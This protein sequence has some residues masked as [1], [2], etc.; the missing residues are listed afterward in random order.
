MPE[1]HG[2][3]RREFFARTAGGALGLTGVSLLAACGQQTPP[4]P[5]AAPKPTEAAKPAAAGQATAAP[6]PAATAQPAATAAPTAAPAAAAKPAAAPKPAAPAAKPGQALGAN[7]I[8]KLEGPEVVTDQ[9]TWPK[10]FKE[11]PMLAERVKAGKLPPVEQRVPQEPLVIK[12]VHEI[13]KYGGIWRRGFT[14]PGDKWNGYRA[15]SG[16]DNV[17]FWDYTGE[18]LVPNVAKDWK[19]EDGGKV[20]TLYLRKGMKW[21]DG[22]PFTADAFTFW[23]EDLYS[24]KELLPAGHSSMTINGKPGRVEKVDDT[25]VRFVFPDPYFLLADVL[26]G[27]T[28]LAS[29]SYYGMEFMGAFAPGHYLKQ[30]HPKYTSQDQVNKLAKDAG[31]D[32]WVTMMKFKNDWALNAELPV[33]TPWI[34]VQPINTPQW[35]LERNPYSMWVDTEGNQ[36]PYI[37]KIQMNLGENLEVV[38]LRAVAGEYDFQ[39]RH[40]DA[41]KIPVFLENQEKG[42]YKLHLDPGDY[43]TDCVIKFNLSY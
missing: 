24:N 5:T 10:S 42:N 34:T 13:G 1:T 30:F 32:N 18:K 6:K 25:T 16:P 3:S 37:D 22:Q 35:I 15:A 7:L 28:A 29:Q 19:F 12:P 41:G 23:F 2:L 36:L 40:M 26:A 38:N 11:A 27:S 39:A 43:G 31:F 20:L 4:A 21:S 8:G 9:G 17:L 33:V 14:G